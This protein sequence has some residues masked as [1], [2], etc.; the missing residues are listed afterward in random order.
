MKSHQTDVLIIGA[1]I[2]G[3]ATAYYLKKLSSKL[4]VTIV[5]QLRPMSYTS[6]Q[7]GE[8]YRNWWPHP[9]MQSFTGRS[10][11]LMEDISLRINDRISLTRRGY[12]LA[13]RKKDFSDLVTEIE[14]CYSNVL[15]SDSNKKKNIRFHSSVSR[16]QYTS[17]D[18]SRWQGAPDGVDFLEGSRLINRYFPNLDPE[19][20]NIVH[21]R[22]AGMVDS[23]QMATFMLE[24]FKELGGKLLNGKVLKIDKTEKFIVSL[25]NNEASVRATR[26]VDAA[27][28]FINEFAHQLGLRLPVVNV[29]QQKIA[30][31][32]TKNAIPRKL[33]FVIDLDEQKIDWRQEDKALFKEDPEF[34]WLAD[35]FP[36]FIHCRPEGG[37]SANWVK[38]GWAYNESSTEALLEPKLDEY[39]PEIVLRGAAR[40]NPALKVYYDGLPRKMIHYGGYYTKTE[41]NWPLIGKTDVEGFYLN[42]AM[43][44]FGT[45]AACAGGELCAQSIL[46]LE[47]PEYSSVLS[48]ERYK[49][50]EFMD[51]LSQYKTGIL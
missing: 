31:P 32:D 20:N 3:I 49:D 18:S 36:G 4:T 6:A 9:V 50:L 19:I 44:G 51:D 37:D 15:V 35:K 21:I 42:G 8:N 28:P 16:S 12:L 5:D 46:D 48:L 17:P 45:M 10:I 43:S 40:L 38:L 25:D 14:S 26:V 34:A 27:G 41:E 33:P 30:F 22:N 39:Y 7:S 24:C 23:Q 11:K 29:L 13:T 47:L 2:V 1:G